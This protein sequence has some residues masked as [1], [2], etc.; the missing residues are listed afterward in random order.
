LALKIVFS[1]LKLWAKPDLSKG[2]CMSTVQHSG[3]SAD[4]S[5]TGSAEVAEHAP[6]GNPIHHTPE[7]RARMQR[8]LAGLGSGSPG[9]IHSKDANSCAFAIIDGLVKSEMA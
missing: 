1:I 6:S 8:R 2:M 3:S 5:L 9:S 4:H 7:L